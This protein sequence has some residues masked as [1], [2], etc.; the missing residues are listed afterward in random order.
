MKLFL[1][2]QAILKEYKYINWNVNFEIFYGKDNNDINNKYAEILEEIE[3]LILSMATYDK[4]DTNGKLYLNQNSNYYFTE[5][6]NNK[7][8]IINYNVEGYY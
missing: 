1:L 6:K 2:L 5:E 8:D 7:K 4:I 3:K